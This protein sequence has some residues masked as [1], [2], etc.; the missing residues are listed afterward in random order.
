MTENCLLIEK[1]RTPQNRNL[2]SLLTVKD[3]NKITVMYIRKNAQFKI[4]LL[5]RSKYFSSASKEAKLL[6]DEKKIP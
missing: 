5:K 2:L 1:L 6:N 3:E 4:L